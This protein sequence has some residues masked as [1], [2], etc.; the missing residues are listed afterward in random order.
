MPKE[1][2]ASRVE[3]ARD[4]QQETKEQFRSALERFSEVMDIRGTEQ[5][6][7][8]YKQLDREYK[9]S[10]AK[11]EEVR[12]RIGAVQTVAID[13]FKEWKKELDEYGDQSLRRASENKLEETRKRY[14][15][16]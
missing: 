14:R 1:A 8:K 12:E 15:K 9:R 4:G 2:S 11:A 10:R 13:L 16:N 5:L 3:K 6:E 7:R